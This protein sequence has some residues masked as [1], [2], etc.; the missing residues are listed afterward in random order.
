MR[1]QLRPSIESLE[2]RNLL[3]SMS[4]GVVANPVA[5]VHLVTDPIWPPVGA[6]MAR[7]VAGPIVAPVTVVPGTGLPTSP[8][9]ASIT[10]N[11]ASYTPGQLVTMTFTETNDTNAIVIVPIGPSID[12]FSITN[13]SQT[14]W[15]S[16][17]G[18]QSDVLYLERLAPGQSITLTAS[19]TATSAGTYSVA[20]QLA[21]GVTT[22]FDIVASQAIV[23]LPPP[24]Q[25]LDRN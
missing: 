4:L 19:W 23:V 25:V 9:Q 14:I 12:G 10:T 13:G 24:P 2:T 3:S 6:H 16:N 22:S 8:L 5:S 15:T 1:Q 17:S 21:P 20:N 18:P 7:P 11:Q